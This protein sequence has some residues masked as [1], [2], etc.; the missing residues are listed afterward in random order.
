MLESEELWL[1][2]PTP[3]FSGDE[4]W[5]K[6]GCATCPGHKASYQRRQEDNLSDQCSSH[7]SLL[8]FLTLDSSFLF[9]A[10]WILPEF[11]LFSFLAFSILNLETFFL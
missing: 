9:K 5:V 2:S 10:E 7:Q 3:Y 6:R 8:V 1:S 4:P 11:L